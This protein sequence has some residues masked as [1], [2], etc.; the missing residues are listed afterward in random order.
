M[1]LCLLLCNVC[2]CILTCCKTILILKT[3]TWVLYCL[4]LRSRSPHNAQHSTSKLL[5][6][7]RPRGVEHVQVRICNM[8]VRVILCSSNCCSCAQ[9]GG[10]FSDP[11]NQQLPRRR[12]PSQLDEGTTG[13][14]RCSRHFHPPAA[15]LEGGCCHSR[16]RPLCG[17]G[18][19]EGCPLRS[20]PL[21]GS[22][23]HPHGGGGD[24]GR[25]G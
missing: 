19:E 18:E 3:A 22:N 23:L 13:R 12:V 7:T 21:C 25:L 20:L 17:R 9:E 10:A 14:P 16:P 24:P 11:W 1:Y 5:T 15:D 2:K 6:C 8:Y 4:R